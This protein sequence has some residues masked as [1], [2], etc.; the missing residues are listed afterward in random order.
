MKALWRVLQ[1]VL[2]EDGE[3]G[4][5]VPQDDAAA[6]A[7][8][9]LNANA[10]RQNRR[11]CIGLC[12]VLLLKRFLVQAYHVQE[13]ML[14]TYNPALKK[15]GSP[16]SHAYAAHADTLP[17]YPPN[18]APHISCA[19]DSLDAFR[20]SACVLPSA[21]TCVHTSAWQLSGQLRRLCWSF[22]CCACE[23]G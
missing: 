22:G 21:A 13:E 19:A 14:Q 4:G 15:C 7:A 10:I 8:Q 5:A 11:A 3:A 2:Q 1:M 20:I 23:E 12:M 18:A 17:R 9:G 16:A 6:A